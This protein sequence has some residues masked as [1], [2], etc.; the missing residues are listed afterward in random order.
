MYMYSFSLEP[1]SIFSPLPYSILD[2]PLISLSLKCTMGTRDLFFLMSGQSLKGL[3]DLT[4]SL[5][6][7]LPSVGLNGGEKYY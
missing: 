7:T 1:L 4:L 6:G 2:I 3:S 5:I